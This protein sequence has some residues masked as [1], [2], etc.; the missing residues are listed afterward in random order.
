MTMATY[1]IEIGFNRKRLRHPATSMAALL[2]QGVTSGQGVTVPHPPYKPVCFNIGD[3]LEIKAYDLST[4]PSTISAMSFELLF[5][6]ALPDQDQ[7]SP[8]DNNTPLSR[9]K[10]YSEG[11]GESTY[12]QQSGELFIINHVDEGPLFPEQQLQN[13]GSGGPAPVP[14]VVSAEGSFYYTILL[15]VTWDNN[16]VQKNF[17]VDPE[18]ITTIDPLP[19]QDSKRD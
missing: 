2:S 8:I 9:F 18:M 13:P 3:Q 6:P 17:R 15:S 4:A 19:P 10:I 1:S 11:L 16:P 12:F 14:L 7:L 5:S